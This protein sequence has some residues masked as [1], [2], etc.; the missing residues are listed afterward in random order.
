M[1]SLCPT[2]T[3]VSG[4]RRESTQTFSAMSYL[5]R[6]RG[7]FSLI[8]ILSVLA[9]ISIMA[10][11]SLP[12]ISGLTQSSSLSAGGND[13][14]DLAVLAHD[15]AVSHNV[16][17]A[18]VGVTTAPTIPNAQYRAFVVMATDQSG[19]NW[20]PVSKWA[21]LPESVTMSSNSSVNT[22]LSPVSLPQ[23]FPTYVSLNG[24]AVN[25]SNCAYQFFY[26]DGHMNTSSSSVV[27]RIVSANS[28]ANYYDLIFNPLTGTIKI[29]RP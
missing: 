7:A 1:R 18:L 19:N 16:M 13:L 26:P 10:V 2:L 22:F 17:T 11:L 21:W 12:S 14:A 4:L 23:N 6:S 20:T 28:Q 29:N 8:E 5:R 27:L 25:S 9:V 3:W 24:A 15:Y